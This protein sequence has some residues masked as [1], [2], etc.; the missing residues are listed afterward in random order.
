MVKAVEGRWGVKPVRQP[1]TAGPEHSIQPVAHLQRG[2]MRVIF[3]RGSGFTEPFG[4]GL[5]LEAAADEM[6]ES[7]I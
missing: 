2:G 3:E 4:Y 5:C 6:P 7:C 1:S